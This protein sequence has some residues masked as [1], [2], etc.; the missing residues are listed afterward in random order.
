MD[1][2]RDNMTEKSAYLNSDLKLPKFYIISLEDNNTLRDYFNRNP[3]ENAEYIEITN[4]EDLKRVSD[5]NFFFFLTT[6]GVSE[7]FSEEIKRITKYAHVTVAVSQEQITPLT[8][9]CTTFFEISNYEIVYNF[10]KDFIYLA[11]NPS[12]LGLH[13]KDIREF[14][15]SSQRFLLKRYEVKFNEKEKFIEKIKNENESMYSCFAI[16]K[17]GPKMSLEIINWFLEELNDYSEGP[18]LA[19]GITREDESDWFELKL[20]VSFSKQEFK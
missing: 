10:L 3:I 7:S 4:S 15:S 19:G 16:F 17:G 2:K 9:A 20:F 1:K 8:D 12:L 6:K 5:G 14:F 13:Y 11:L 18:I